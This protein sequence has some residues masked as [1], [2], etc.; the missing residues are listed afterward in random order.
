MPNRN[1][2]Q[3]NNLTLAESTVS[4]PKKMREELEQKKQSL[5]ENLDIKHEQVIPESAQREFIFPIE[6]L[7]DGEYEHV[8]KYEN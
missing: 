2:K 5:L 6:N 4:V 1:T 7:P 8:I 3:L